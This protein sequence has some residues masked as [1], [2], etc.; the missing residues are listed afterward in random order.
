[1]NQSVSD[2]TAPNSV[3]PGRRVAS[4]HLHRRLYDW[5]LHWA[6]TPYG[7]PALFVLAFAE[8]SFFPVPPDALL[9]PLVLGNR[10]K[11]VQFAV[12]CSLASV[13]GGMA[14]YGIGRFAWAQ[15]QSVFHDHVPG[16]AR[17]SI[18]LQGEAAPRPCLI[19]NAQ[20]T[21]RPFL[22]T[23]PSWPMEVVYPDGTRAV[24]EREAVIEDEIDI[25]EYTRVITAYR[26]P[27]VG[28]VVVAVAGFTPIPYKVITI[29]AGAAHIS[30]VVFLIVSTLSRSAR[31]FLVAGLF[32]LF[33]DRMKPL[34]D[35]YFNWLCLV[36]VGLLVGGF[37]ALRYIGG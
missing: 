13:V 22:A 5:V 1:M 7:G 24:L 16:F 37:L 28:T 17:D 2:D 35:R 20:V 10:R 32:G 6:D 23:E 15:F 12:I 11:W 21:L 25:H 27:T 34:I 4:W 8:S 14:G 26:D 18:R 9:G 31:F 33:G 29:T 3:E 30:L 19:E 36:F